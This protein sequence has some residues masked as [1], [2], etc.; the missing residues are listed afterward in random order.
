M[1]PRNAATAPRLPLRRSR[2]L[3]CLRRRR[4]ASGS[5][6]VGATLSAAPLERPVA[7]PS[8]PPPPLLPQRAFVLLRLPQRPHLA[9]MF[10]GFS[11]GDSSSC[12][13]QLRSVLF[14]FLSF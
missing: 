4:R 5:F 11:V 12:L 3:P 13:L 7:P 10:S 14:A 8:P 1:P 2:G 6:P 9:T